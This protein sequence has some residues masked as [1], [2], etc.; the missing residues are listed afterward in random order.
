MKLSILKSTIQYKLSQGKKLP[1]DAILAS[2]IFEAMYYVC[3]RCVP[4]ELVKTHMDYEE[5]VLRHL[6]GG[7]FIAIP[8]YPDFSKLDRHLLIDEDLTYA[9]IYYTCFI[10]GRSVD[11]KAM[12][13]DIINEHISKEGDG[14]YGSDTI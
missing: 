5:K 14:I 4:S 7:R 10:I 2:I 6:S 12:A 9:V 3:G 11:D 8:E 13:D 1:D